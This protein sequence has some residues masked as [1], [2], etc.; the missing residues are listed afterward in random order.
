MGRIWKPDSKRSHWTETS[1][2]MF[3]RLDMNLHFLGSKISCKHAGGSPLKTCHADLQLSVPF[4]QNRPGQAPRAF[5]AP[6][7]LSLCPW[8]PSGV[9]GSR[10]GG[11]SWGRQRMGS[12]CCYHQ[13]QGWMNTA[14]SAPTLPWSPRDQGSAPGGLGALHNNSGSAF[15]PQLTLEWVL[16]T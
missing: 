1:K 14:L 6:Q 9:S 12:L 5:P 11:R 10:W 7:Q 2:I 15:W 3:N 4:R 13:T 16:H 8:G